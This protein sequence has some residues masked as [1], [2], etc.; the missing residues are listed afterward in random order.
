MKPTT[1]TSL[2]GPETT[3]ETMQAIVQERYGL[4]PDV[5]LSLAE[6]ARP[7]VGAGEVL[8]RVV[9]ASVDQGTWHCMTGM[10]SAM[11]LIGFGLRA[12]KALNP[13][14][15]L[16]GTVEA[17]GSDVTD[18]APGDEVYG[19]GDGAFAE[20]ASVDAS[21]LARKPAD[22]SFEAAAT[23]PI[24]GGTALQAVRKAGVTAGQSVLITGASGGVGTFAVQIAKAF[25]AEVT[26]VCSGAK[27]DLVESLGADH[28]ID[29]QQTDVTAADRRYDVILD[30]GGARRLSDLRRILAD[31]GT[32][33]IVG[34]E[35]DGKVLGDFTRSLRAVLLSPFVRPSLGML[36]STENAASLDELGGLIESG[37]ITPAVDRAFPLAETAAAIRHLSE[38]KARGKIV[39]TT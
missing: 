10:P 18:F 22:V 14:R 26:G 36:A 11:R 32:L 19:S 9:A 3:P 39:I 13:G 21:R 25:G 8:V 4:D 31:D 28:V 37:Q 7:T 33:V 30:L 1:T 17:V 35:N 2:A 6:I 16:A 12:P 27:V 23:V 24:S 15:S 34:G 20:Y 38:G 5:V 29:Y